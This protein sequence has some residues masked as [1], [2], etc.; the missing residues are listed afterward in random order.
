MSRSVRDPDYIPVEAVEAAAKAMRANEGYDWDHMGV[1][2]NVETRLKEL[3]RRQA[4]AILEAAAPHMLAAALNSAA[5]SL[6]LMPPM[7]RE[8]YVT[9]LKLYADEPWRLKAQ[10]GR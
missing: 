3:Y 1:S 8:R 4:H 5:E 7:T 2:R 6:G 10:Y 9:T